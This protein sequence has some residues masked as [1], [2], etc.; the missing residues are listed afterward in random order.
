MRT[1]VVGVDESE[2]ARKAFHWAMGEARAHG[3]RVVL[4]HA[5]QPLSGYYPYSV[6]EGQHL[7]AGIE[8]ETRQ[9][10]E[11]FIQGLLAE[12]E[13]DDV[14]VEAVVTRGRASEAL[15]ERAQHAD[16]VVVGSRGHGGFTGLLLGSVSQQVVHH[17]PCPVVVVPQ[18]AETP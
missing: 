4:V 2:G 7:R 15:L 8:E 11:T 9:A 17:A 16:L 3:A 18:R 6:A 14:E 13:G 10:A 1:V 12:V 5:F